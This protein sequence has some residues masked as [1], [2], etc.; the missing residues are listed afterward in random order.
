MGMER[1]AGRGD[2]ATG[3]GQGWLTDVVN[4]TC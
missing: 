3:R 4:D 1:H 2:G